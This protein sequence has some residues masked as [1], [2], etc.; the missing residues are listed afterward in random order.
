MLVCSK[1]SVTVQI[2]EKVVSIEPKAICLLKVEGDNLAIYDLS[3][4]HKNSVQIRSNE[5]AVFLQP[6]QDWRESTSGNCPAAGHRRSIVSSTDS[7]RRYAQGEVSLL[8]T[9]EAS[10]LL[11]SL[12]KSNANDDRHLCGKILKAAA[13]LSVVTGSHGPYGAFSQ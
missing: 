8:S 2:G 11:Q 1:Q 13:A 5:R 3:D 7:G 12:R 10:V 9:V 4:T 6:G